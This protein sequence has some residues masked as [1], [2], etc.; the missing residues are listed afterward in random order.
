MQ[1]AARQLAIV[2]LSWLAIV[3]ASFFLIRAMPGDPVQ[4]FLTSTNI[5]A[6]HELAAEYRAAWGLEGPLAVQFLHWLKGFVSLEW[7]M[8]FET[9]GSVFA[10]LA[11]RLPW[12]AAIGAGGMAIA[13]VVGFAL[14]FYAASN[15]DGIADRLSR[16]LAVAG[17]ALPSFAVG[18]ILLWFLAAELQWLR[19]YSGGTLERLLLPICLVALFSIGSVSRIVRAAFADVRVAGYFR[20]ALG[21]G[22]APDT[23]LWRHGRRHAA[24]T[25]MAGFAPELAWIVGGTA[26]AEIVFGVPGVSERIVEAVAARDYAVLQPYVALMALWIIL[27]LQGAAVLRRALDPRIG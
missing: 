5:T 26:V 15:P 18:L 13:V 11:A 22:L 27:V 12:S 25:L 17:Q 24:L 7:G 2:G 21:K 23:A 10:D 3:A 19:P 6:S 4:R 1:A 9:G 20:T 8:S 16:L 14:G